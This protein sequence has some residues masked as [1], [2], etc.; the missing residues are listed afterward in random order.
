MIRTGSILRGVLTVA[1]T[2]VAVVAITQVAAADAPQPGR[3]PQYSPP[4]WLIEPRDGVMRAGAPVDPLVNFVSA[5]ENAQTAQ[6][7][8]SAR[9]VSAPTAAFPHIEVST[10]DKNV[11]GYVAPSS[12]IT[13]QLV[14]GAAVV[15]Y[16]VGRSDNLGSFVPIQYYW[17]GKVAPILAGDTV[18][19]YAGAF[20]TTTTI[21][22]MTA[23]F[24]ASNGLLTGKVTGVAVP[25]SVALNLLG[26]T[27]TVMTDGSGNFAFNANG[28]F[29][30]GQQAWA[31]LT[32]RADG[33]NVVNWSVPARDGIH[34]DRVLSE[35]TGMT[36]PGVSVAY[37]ARAADTTVKASGS[38]QADDTGYWKFGY[39]GMATGD[40][41][42]VTLAGM[43]H[44]MMTVANLNVTANL[45][46]SVLSGNAPPN[47]AV[48]LWVWRLAGDMYFPHE[49]RTTANG[50]GNFSV[51]SPIGFH[52]YWSVDAFYRDANGNE[53]MHWYIPPSANVNMTYNNVW[54][55]ANPYVSVDVQLQNG[56]DVYQWT[57]ETGDT[58]YYQVAFEGAPGVSAGDVV[59]VTGDGIF[60][61]V[62]LEDTNSHVN[63]STD[64]IFG[65][66]PA[67]AYV[68]ATAWW[69]YGYGTIMFAREVTAA[70]DGAFVVN[71]AGEH[72][73][74][75]G[76]AGH[77]RYIRPDEHRVFTHWYAPRIQVGLP[78]N[79]VFGYLPE[80]G[81][82]YT[83]TIAGK[84]MQTGTSNGDRSFGNYDNFNGSADITIGDVITVSTDTWQQTIV[85]K[86][87]TIHVDADTNMV[88]GT[89]PANTTVS[90][91]VGAR[92]WSTGSGTYVPSNAAGIYMA[93]YS[94]IMDIMPG[95]HAYVGYL[96]E[97]N[98]EVYDRLD[99]PY[100]FARVN[101]DHNWVCGE[102]SSG[103]LVTVTLWRA[104]NALD[105]QTR[106]IDMAGG[107]YC[108][109]FN[110]YNIQVGDV[111][112]VVT[113]IGIN[114]MIDVIPMSGSVDPANDSI[115]GH[116]DAPVCPA[117]VRAELWTHNGINVEGMTD[118][119]CNYDL[120]LSPKD[121]RIGDMVALWYIRPD[122]NEVGIVR[123]KLRMDVALDDDRVG[124]NA[125]P[126]ATLVFTLTGS[127][128]K[129]TGSVVVD[130]NGNF[131]TDIIWQG[132]DP[133]NTL[134]ASYGTTSVSVVMPVTLTAHMDVN[135]D[136]ISGVGPTNS[137]VY[138]NVDGSPIGE[139]PTATDG[140]GNYSL[141]TNSDPWYFDLQPEHNGRVY[142]EDAN[143]QRVQVS[144]GAVELEIQ[145]WGGCCGEATPGGRF[146]YEI[147]YRAS[148]GRPAND[149]VI[150]DTLPAG[151]TYLSNTLGLPAKVVGNLVIFH[152]GFL[153]SDYDMYM[154]IFV[155]MSD[156][157][158]AGDQI[159]NEI[160]IASLSQADANPGNNTA[161]HEMNLS[162]NHTNLTVWKNPRTGDPTPG[163][164][165][166]WQ[167][168]YNNKGSTGS[169]KVRITDTLPISTT[170]VR[171]WADEPGWTLVMS[172]TQIVWERVLIPG[173][174]GNW[175]YMVVMLHPD[176]GLNTELVNHVAIYTT[177]E[178]NWDDNENQNSVWTREPRHDLRIGKSFDGGITVPGKDIWYGIHYN[179]DGNTTAHHVLVTDTLPAGVTYLEAGYHDQYGWHALPYSY[180]AGNQYVWDLGTLIP[181]A[182][183]NFQIRVRIDS[184]IP[185]YMTLTNWVMI[186]GDEEDNWMM[187]NEASL[188]VTVYP[189]GPNLVVSKT[190]QW[191]GWGELEYEIKVENRGDSD[192]YNFVV[193]DTYPIST[194]YDTWWWQWGP[195][196]TQV[197]FN[198]SDAHRGV[199][200]VT[201]LNAGNSF[202]VRLK[203]KVEDAAVGD[204]TR[205][206]TNTVQ[207]QTVAGETE[208]ADNT[209]TLVDFTGPDLAVYNR[210]TG[211]IPAAGALIT[212]TLDYGNRSS[213]MDAE[214]NTSWVV[215]Q[216]PT[217]MSLVSVSQ[218][219]DLVLGPYLVW[220]HGRMHANWWNT[221]Q[222]V[223]QITTTAQI[224]DSFTTMASVHDRDNTSVE[225]NYDN[226]Y[227]WVTLTI[228]N[229]IQP[230]CYLP[231]VERQ[232]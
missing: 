157:L 92:D 142:V 127:P 183:G 150:T 175:I 100:S 38:M 59:T 47:A 208:P 202:A 194:T 32:V 143:A 112:E 79:G 189:S 128:V 12:V 30:A 218:Q 174:Y 61:V 37:T 52:R 137:T 69:D 122:G 187:N 104:G 206:F 151:V 148:W 77:V 50:S 158:N 190:S 215:Y 105:T 72:D 78:E 6:D 185:H 193:T 205:L 14:R 82:N 42:S 89:A 101:K 228:E 63:L 180:H 64:T 152:I 116:V 28:L 110:N 5:R 210:H 90:M 197:D 58:G 221:I 124:G 182:W 220:L 97:N 217:G 88:T 98:N 85:V 44:V 60:A 230:R 15:G 125:E 109:N 144:F 176:V 108:L 126:G 130:E 153:H 13:T 86:P 33:A 8:Y 76:Y 198:G 111:V 29:I 21:P 132:I 184:A 99:T 188:D 178:T 80:A 26:Y 71:V 94:E 102:V 154:S 164:F 106:D 211:G 43:K 173:N 114:A 167:I 3:I 24:T 36:T 146:Q 141:N 192:V 120:N 73:L 225:P 51:V 136:T 55:F 27:A 34:A 160:E 200:S 19:V 103:P 93:D 22:G 226:N 67:N 17:Q 7:T 199:F 129:W 1:A 46:T 65:N 162:E 196:E 48:Q 66:V 171:W 40:I 149:V 115:S 168:G 140:S 57:G 87:F 181:G 25:T 117:N 70:N 161:S 53:T 68:N 74:Y 9:S 131:G 170:F 138:V 31:M 23:T 56:V 81:Q 223:T 201:Q 95:A 75:N 191:N 169:G 163:E 119:D 186:H 147:R 41:I 219:P 121:V 177:N 20:Y 133:G 62:P 209:Y 10:W 216:L 49:I 227:A 231:L 204:P 45:A 224:G 139:I 39:A 232:P 179:N 156:S 118:A 123:V 107:G 2:L 172:G 11:S 213:Q 84:D 83:I 222:I 54:G 207:V 96:D 113:S 155:E 159:H 18:R 134:V 165:M 145:K 214:G 166:I 16:G 91:Y 195:G 229:P 4:T 135:A 212:Y 203:L 35:V